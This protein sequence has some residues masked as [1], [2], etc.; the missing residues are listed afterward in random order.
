MNNYQALTKLKKTQPN[1]NHSSNT[2]NDVVITHVS[3]IQNHSHNL[4][5]HRLIQQQQQQQQ[6]QLN[7]QSLIS[8][9][10][11]NEHTKQNNYNVPPGIARPIP[12]NQS[13][14]TNRHV[15]GAKA[16]VSSNLYNSYQY[17]QSSSPYLATNDPHMA[18][19][20][21]LSASSSSSSL[22]SASSMSL[23]SFSSESI[24]GEQQTRKRKLENT[25]TQNSFYTE[26]LPLSTKPNMAYDLH[27]KNLN[28]SISESQQQT[29]Q[30]QQQ[31]NQLQH[32]QSKRCD[33]EC[34]SHLNTNTNTVR[35]AHFSVPNQS[36]YSPSNNYNNSSISSNS[37][38]QQLI[39][40]QAQI[41]HQANN[42]NNN[43]VNRHVLNNNSTQ[44]QV[45]TCKDCNADYLALKQNGNNRYPYGSYFQQQHQLQHISN[46]YYFF[47]DFLRFQIEQN[48]KIE[49]FYL[50]VFRGYFIFLG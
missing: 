23:S 17:K 48:K 36:N 34:C 32:S 2:N 46:N 28:C 25:N 19:K 42:T 30:P 31:L 18:N 26:N 33:K 20:P 9:R 43:V 12:I 50:T 4:H 11:S 35:T 22:S 15:A 49:W 6:Q 21:L 10:D 1:V 41:N 45:C 37:H 24:N 29:K 44:S 38:N 27:Q 47:N 3:Q 39:A 13:Y 16:G 5:S 8:K 7:A 40:V 14:T